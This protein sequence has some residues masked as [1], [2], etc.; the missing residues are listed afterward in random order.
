MRRSPG[1]A[2]A[3]HQSGIALIEALVG[4]LIFA[5]G[6]LG[7]VGLQA[8]MTSAQ[9]SAKFRGDASNLA[10]ELIG[11]MWG[12][13]PVNYVKYTT[14]DCDS[15]PRC[16]EWL[17]KAAKVLPGGGSALD[18]NSAINEVSITVTW[19]NSDGNSGQFTTSA[20]VQP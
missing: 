18:F 20:R 11:V 4:I 15:H 5:F 10:N 6:V 3:Q 13:A 8:S 2:H 16:N 7:L 1:F 9:S 12:D 14:A 17:K 19:K